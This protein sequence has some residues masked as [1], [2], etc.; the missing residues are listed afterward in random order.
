MDTSS[1]A[2]CRIFWLLARHQDIQ[3]KLRAEIREARQNF[4]EPNYD[5]LNA[6][7]YLDAIIRETLRLYVLVYAGLT[8]CGLSLH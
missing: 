7:P 8:N 5:Q 4:E 6:L 1:S 3:D 2:L